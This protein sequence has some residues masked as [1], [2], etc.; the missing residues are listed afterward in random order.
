MPTLRPRARA[1]LLSLAGST[2]VAAAALAGPPWLSI[3]LPANPLDPQTREAY[4]VVRTYH[5]DRSVPLP[6][7]GRAEG[8]VNGTKRVVPLAFDRTDQ[9]GAWALRKQWGDEGAWVLVITANP[10]EGSVTA[11]VSIGADGGVRRVEVPA[12]R[13]GRHTVPVRVTQADVDRALRAIG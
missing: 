7:E 3:E 6:L 12:R 2:L 13:E 4:L 1:L 11:L 10:G 5:H 9:Q 8:M